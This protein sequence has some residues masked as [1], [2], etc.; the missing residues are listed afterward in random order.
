[1]GDTSK[2][3]IIEEWVRVKY[4]AEYRHATYSPDYNLHRRDD[5]V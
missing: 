3:S 2:Q 1:M 4:E 5:D